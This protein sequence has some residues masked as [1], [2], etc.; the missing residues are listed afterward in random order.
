M[1]TLIVLE[2]M[3]QALELVGAGQSL[4]EPVDALL[5]GT[6][7]RELAA[8]LPV[9][10]VLA[11]DDP[12]LRPSQAET[13]APLVADA[14]KQNGADVVLFPH[15]LLAR[16]L[17]PRVAFRLGTAAVTDAVALKRE[18]GRVVLTK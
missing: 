17:A 5:V 10:R 15:A 12:S 14:V 13:W 6:G 1:S 11:A 4:G 8:Q 3:A 2:G 18:E 7:V 9:R 16:E